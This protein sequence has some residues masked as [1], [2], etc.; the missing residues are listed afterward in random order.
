MLTLGALRIAPNC[1]LTSRSQ[2]PVP[3]RGT[4]ASYLGVGTK[5]IDI[6]GM[7]PLHEEAR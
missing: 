6:G 7:H 2:V 1:L 5:V 3:F 4:L